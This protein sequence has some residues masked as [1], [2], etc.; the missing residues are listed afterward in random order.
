MKLVNQDERP[1][2]RM[3]ATHAGPS[4][5]GSADFKNP[6]MNKGNFATT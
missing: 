3:S 6:G 4:E 5:K 2:K 1:R